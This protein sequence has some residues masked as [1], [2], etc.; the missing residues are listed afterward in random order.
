MVIF[1]IMANKLAHYNKQNNHHH[2]V[3]IL[4]YFQLK[5]ISHELDEE[6]SFRT[7]VI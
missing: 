4:K 3:L 7:R 1:L 2:F 5:L 6:Y